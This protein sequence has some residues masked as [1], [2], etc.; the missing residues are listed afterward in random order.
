[1][2]PTVPL[3]GGRRVFQET[4]K[5]MGKPRPDL[6]VFAGVQSRLTAIRQI[7][8]GLSQSEVLDRDLEDITIQLNA[9]AATVAYATPEKV[10][11]F[12]F[13]RGEGCLFCGGLGWV[14]EAKLRMAPEELIQMSNA[15]SPDVES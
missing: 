13:G 2:S 5:E 9:L 7:V 12:C 4:E 10:C 11:P 6:G 14:S 8:D 15:S 1:M 3:N